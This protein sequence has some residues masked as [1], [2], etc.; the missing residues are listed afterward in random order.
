MNK[1][2][3]QLIDRM[4]RLYGFEDEIVIMFINFCESY[5]DNDLHDKMLTV[6]VEAHEAMPVIIGE[7]DE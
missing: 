4:I 1:I 7:D 3:E 6:L 5:E 2:R